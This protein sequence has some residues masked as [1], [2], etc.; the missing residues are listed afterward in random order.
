MET[1]EKMIRMSGI[2]GKISVVVPVMN[3]ES[4][5]EE[6]FRRMRGM[7]KQDGRDYEVIIIND[8]STDSSY[9]ILKT[10]PERDPKF[11]IIHFNRNFG[12][13]AAITAGFEEATGE[14]VVII[15]GDLQL[16]PYDILKLIEQL[17]NG[18]DVVCG[19][20]QKRPESFWARQLPSRFANKVL[21]SILGVE[22]N[23]IG[24]GLQAFRK[25]Y[26]KGPN[27]YNPMYGHAAIFSVWRGGKFTEVPVS[28]NPR[29]HGRTKYDWIRLI[30]Y[31]LDIL[32]TF[33]MKPIQLTVFFLLGAL[34]GL[35]SLL[36]LVGF[37]LAAALGSAPG[38]IWWA[39]V[40]FVGLTGLQILT[41]GIQYE[42][43]NRIN[44]RIIENPVYVIDHIIGKEGIKRPMDNENKSNRKKE[45]PSSGM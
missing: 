29:K 26:L 21:S 44:N 42:R 22:Y 25:K 12:Q 27:Q 14:Y 33:S 34:F 39:L 11:K 43:L 20:R 2:P 45:N 41:N 9:E 35:A 5:L 23:D 8:G 7:L 15:D 36:I 37:V 4:N 32:I 24:C 6:L 1:K 16:D 3:E 28:F 13:Q 17:D 19:D 31:F 40:I 38:P 18:F 30:S 10:F